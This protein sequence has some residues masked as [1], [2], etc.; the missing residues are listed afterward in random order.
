MIGLFIEI[1]KLVERTVP[2]SDQRHQGC[3]ADAEP[4]SNRPNLTRP[5]ISFGSMFRQR[6]L[7]DVRPIPSRDKHPRD[8]EAKIVAMIIGGVPEAQGRAETHWIARP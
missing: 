3:H 4:A 7:R 6:R 2:D 8:A 1:A 5:A